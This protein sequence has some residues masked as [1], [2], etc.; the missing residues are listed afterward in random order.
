MKK[1]KSYQIALLVFLSVLTN[2]FGRVIADKAQLPL[3]MDSFGTFL[4]AYVLGPFCGAIVGVSGNVLYS[5]MDPISFVFS[6]NSVC[7]AFVVGYLAKQGWMRTF[8][9]TMSLSV[10][11]TIVC[12]T[13]ASMLNL[14]FL[15]GKTSNVWGNGIIE[16]FASWNV[17]ITIC[18]IFGQFYVDFLDKVF[19]LSALYAFIRLYR[20]LRPN[21]PSFLKLQLISAKA[22]IFAIASCLLFGTAKQAD[23]ETRNYNAYV[24]TVYNNLNGLPAGEANDI[25]STNDG[26]MWI[27]TYAGLYR[28]NGQDFRLMNEFSSIKAVKCLY[29][30]DEGRLLV[31]TNDSGLSI[32]I[33]ETV[34]NVLE[35]KDGLPSDF[36]RCIVRG[37]DGLYYVG[38]TKEMAVLSITEGLGIYSIIPEIEAAVRVSAD[39]N[40]H[41]AVVTKGG[42]LFVLKGTRIVYSTQLERERFTSVSFSPDGLL[43]AATEKNKVIVMS[44]KDEVSSYNV[45]TESD[46]Q[47]RVLV[48]QLKTIFCGTLRHVNSIDFRE[49]V[50]FLCADNGVGYVSDGVFYGIETGSFNNSIDHMTLDYQGNL[51]F[52]SSRLGLLKMS[53]SSF[54]E[55]YLSS[56]FEGTV[57][58]SVT[59][60]KGNLYFATDNGLTVIDSATGSA[61]SDSITQMLGNTRIRCLLVDRK[62]SLWICTKSK[63]LINV[64]SDGSISKYCVGH[65][66]RVAVELS[67]GTIAAGTNDGIFFI[68]DGELVSSLTYEDGFEIPIILTLSEKSDGVLLAGTD[69]GGLALIKDRKLLRFIKRSDGLSSNIILRTVS[70]RWNVGRPQGTFV[71]TSN[72]LCYM[73]ANY[74]VRLLSNFPYSNNYDL[75]GDNSGNL[76][77]LSSA[78]IFVVN[79]DE[80]ISG[81][82]LDYELLDHKKGL[83]GSL[84]PNSWNYVDDAGNLYLSCDD[85]VSRLNLNTYDRSDRSYR[86]LMKSI[87]VNGKRHIVQKDIPFIIPAGS[88]MIEIVPEIINY[89]INNPYISIYMAGLDEEP[90]IML[91]S[92]L[93]NIIYTNLR[94]GKY[95]FHIAVLDSKGRKPVEESVY[96][97]VMSYRIYDN[98]WFKVYAIFVFILAIAWLTWY[99]TSTLQNRRMHKQEKEMIIIRNQVRMGNETIFSIANA[100][101]A[102]DKST[103]RHSFRVA[104]YSV[105]I[106]RELGFSEAELESIRKTGLLHDIGKIG[107]PDSILNKPEKLSDEEYEIMK[108]HVVIGGEILKD[109]TLIEHVADGAKYHHERYDGKGYIEGLKGEQIPLNA[110]IIG[111][112][113]A[114]DAM[115]ANRVYRKALDMNYVVSELKRCRGI[116]FDPGLVDILLD[117]IASGKLD[118][119]KIY[120]Q[121]INDKDRFA[122]TKRDEDE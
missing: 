22:L 3:W 109:F 75:V 34:S 2:V 78:G 111:L 112:A 98:W 84:T 113:D 6:I 37:S 57:V 38:T 18:H 119:Q 43:Y 49:N 27:G 36:V 97:L 20:F 12:V 4:T 16:L 95:E 90:S 26:V 82:K 56:G 116:Q 39:E 63:G 19:T 104:E 17:P 96:T 61:S 5:L 71:V 115:T 105:M 31:G 67:D 68:K 92:E 28:H 66:F 23:A 121:S 45:G 52:S 114:F 106:G 10:L 8:L 41:I 40:E 70:D 13:I 64:K 102:R 93:S 24:R 94:A 80:L 87:I 44:V 69:G 89:S 99:A 32:V 110:R 50:M 120:E 25:A 54:E 1:Y 91:Q 107:V 7:I 65:V 100:I 122:E 59:N 73:D 42:V 46:E 76:F 74:K 77:V 118:V 14:L 53:S 11:V 117:L 72:G 103:G 55:V 62:N 60:Y 79:R 81:K 30:D 47:V 33:N 83:R 51:W 108:N 85:G 21:L 35:E 15:N 88:D 9:K 29:V 58:N 101:E 48:K 86:I